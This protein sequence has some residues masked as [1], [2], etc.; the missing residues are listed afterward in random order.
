[1]APGE[2]RS[3]E[4]RKPHWL[5]DLV[6]VVPRQEDVGNMCLARFNRARMITIDLRTHHRGHDAWQIAFV[7]GGLRWRRHRCLPDSYTSRVQRSSRFQKC[8]QNVAGGDDS[9]QPLA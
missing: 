2:R 9:D 5:L 8:A 6:N 3:V 1:M 7:S 4:K